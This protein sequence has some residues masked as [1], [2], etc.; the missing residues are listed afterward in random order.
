[1]LGATT[2]Q[3]PMRTSHEKYRSVLPPNGDYVHGYA[4]HSAGLAL[5][6]Q[7]GSADRLPG[8]TLGSARCRGIHRLVRESGAKEGAWNYRWLSH[9]ALSS[10][11][12]DPTLVVCIRHVTKAISSQRVDVLSHSPEQLG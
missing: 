9:R 12:S 10:V 8:G 5:L 11:P 6:N 3:V 1:M 4:A 7:T 2:C